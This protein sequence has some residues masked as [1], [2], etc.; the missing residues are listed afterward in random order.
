MKWKP[1]IIIEGVHMPI[2]DDFQQSIADLCSED[3]KRTMTG[4]AIKKVI[5]IKSTFP[6]KWEGIEWVKAA[7]LTKA[8][9]GKS[10]LTV[11]AMDIRNPY[12]MTTFEIYVNDRTCKPSKFSDDGKVYW[13]IEFKEIET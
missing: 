9:D 5:A 11:Q 4:T 10:K 13:D 3:S 2:P 12:S 7:E 6:L 8:V 1:E